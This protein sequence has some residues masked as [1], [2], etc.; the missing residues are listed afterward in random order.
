VSTELL[1]PDTAGLPSRADML[2]TASG[3]TPTSRS[4]SCCKGKSFTREGGAAPNTRATTNTPRLAQGAQHNT[5]QMRQ[6]V[7]PKRLRC[8]VRGC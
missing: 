3:G 4:G 7:H 5:P 1:G 8:E 2:W 6:P